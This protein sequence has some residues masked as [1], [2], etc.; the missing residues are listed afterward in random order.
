LLGWWRRRRLSDAVRRRLV[1]ALARAEEQLVEVHVRN[2]LEVLDTVGDELPLDQVVE[3]YLEALDV[4]EPRAS[5][6]ARRVLARLEAGGREKRARPG[7][8]GE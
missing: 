1:I 2:A 5:I 3:I 6:V 7:K 8:A 4:A